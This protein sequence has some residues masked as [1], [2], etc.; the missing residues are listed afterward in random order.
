MTQE[1]P[2]EMR[3]R[4]LAEKTLRGSYLGDAARHAEMATFCRNLGVT[5]PRL[6]TDAEI[7][8]EVDRD[9]PLYAEL[10]E[11]MAD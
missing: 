10:I 8:A 3:A 6:L 4:A 7:M 5:V 11:G 2:I 1:A 9:W